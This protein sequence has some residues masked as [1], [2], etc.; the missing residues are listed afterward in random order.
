[1]IKQCWTCLQLH[2]NVQSTYLEKLKAYAISNITKT[3][4]LHALWHKLIT[5]WDAVET[6]PWNYTVK[7]DGHCSASADL[8]ILVVV[9]YRSR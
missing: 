4:S 6:C 1:V 7:R 3:V 2:S 5:I 9:G 8:F